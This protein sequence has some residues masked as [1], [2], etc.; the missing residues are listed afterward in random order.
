[1][2]VGFLKNDSAYQAY[3]DSVVATPL[4]LYIEELDTIRQN[5]EAFEATFTAIDPLDS[6]EV[7]T[8]IR[9]TEAIILENRLMRDK[10]DALREEMKR[11][12]HFPLHFYDQVL[13]VIE[14]KDFFL[15][16][17]II[18]NMIL[19]NTPQFAVDAS[20]TIL[21]NYTTIT[22]NLNKT[23]SEI[24][25]MYA[26]ADSL[27]RCPTTGLQYN[28]E[29]ALVDSAHA[30]KQ[31][32]VECPIDSAYIENVEADFMRSTIGA[33]TVENHGNIKGGEKSWD[34]KR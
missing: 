31:V 7:D 26:L 19:Q 27:N 6:T 2:L 1:M 3:I 28:L 24:P 11:H 5:Q 4:Q 29:I 16:Y 32:I 30:V 18:R 22:E 21:E 9:Q 20:K 23:L 25:N 12:P 15:Q 8:F 14:R 13:D 34:E 10:L 33:L 17:E